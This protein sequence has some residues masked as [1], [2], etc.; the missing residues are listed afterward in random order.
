MFQLTMCDCKRRP[1]HGRTWAIWCKLCNPGYPDLDSIDCECGRPAEWAIVGELPSK[2]GVHRGLEHVHVRGESCSVLFCHRRPTFGFLDDLR[3]R[4]CRLHSQ[5]GSTC[6][7]PPKCVISGC[8]RIPVCTEGGSYEIY[9]AVHSQEQPRRLLCWCGVGNA[10]YVVGRVPTCR[11]HALPTARNIIWTSCNVR[12][13]VGLASMRELNHD[14]PIKCREHGEGCVSTQYESRLCWCGLPAKYGTQAGDAMRCSMHRRYDDFEL[15]SSRHTENCIYC[16]RRGGPRGCPCYVR[17]NPAPVVR[18]CQCGRRRGPNGCTCVHTRRHPRLLGK[19]AELGRAI[20]YIEYKPVV[21]DY[22][23]HNPIFT[24]EGVNIY[25]GYRNE[26]MLPE[27][28][29]MVD[30]KSVDTGTL[31]TAIRSARSGKDILI[32]G[33][34][35]NYIVVKRFMDISV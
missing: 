7:L 34:N 2:C 4:W 3:P 28:A 29:I 24:V 8:T 12:G 16:N 31:L 35:I 32:T 10:T 30:I 21:S 5:Y 11:K 15:E 13:C 17:M 22:H 26:V 6:I 19:D 1:T 20:D 23:H 27:P 18:R 33:N 9:C 25:D 14:I